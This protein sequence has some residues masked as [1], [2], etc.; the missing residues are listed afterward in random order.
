MAAK[1]SRSVECGKP[2]AE[3]RF[4]HAQKLWVGTSREMRSPN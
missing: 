3:A 4:A 2:E 1:L